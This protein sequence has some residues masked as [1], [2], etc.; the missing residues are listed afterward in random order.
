MQ[1]EGFASVYDTLMA[2]VDYGAW[3]DHI[4]SMLPARASVLECACGTGEISLRLAR[5]GFSVT[6]TDISAEMLSIAQE[7]QRRAGLAL[8]SLR[9][10]RMDMRS[11]ELNK[12]VDAV[13]ACCDGVN[14]LTSREDVKK[15]FSAAYRALKPDGVLIFDISSRYKLENVLGNNCFIDNGREAAYLWQNEYDPETKLIRMELSFFKREGGLYRRI[16]ETHIQRAHS[17]RE[18][19]NWLEETGFTWE[20][21]GFLKDSAPEKDEE[22]IGFTAHKR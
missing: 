6:A 21:K 15:F 2:G 18:L 22:R 12:K 11:P 20:A 3:A 14:Y 7:K 8:S 5:K 9:F 19:G 13:I 17:V 16:D 4:A 10:A 1:Y